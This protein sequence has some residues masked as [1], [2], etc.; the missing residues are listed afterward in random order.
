MTVVS[1][2]KSATKDV[3]PFFTV[4]SVENA[5]D[6]ATIRLFDNQPFTAASSFVVEENDIDRLALTIRP[7]LAENLID[8]IA[9]QRKRL[10][11]VV[12]AANPFL[13]K[14]ELVA[15]SPLTSTTPEEITIGSEVLDRL[16]GGAN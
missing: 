5:L 11:L 12:S 14:T 13:K 3:R 16:G 2:H 9:L 4:A 1:Y 15:S 10:M 7:N 6:E 8:S